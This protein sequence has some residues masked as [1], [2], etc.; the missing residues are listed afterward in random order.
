M[1]TRLFSLKVSVYFNHYNNNM[2]EAYLSI[3]DDMVIFIFLS[4]TI[5]TAEPKNDS[6]LEEEIDLGGVQHNEKV[7]FFLHEYKWQ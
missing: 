5:Y 4:Y 6:E 7:W 3:D 1:I 2:Y